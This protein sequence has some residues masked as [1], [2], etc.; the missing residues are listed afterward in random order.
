[1]HQSNSSV[2]L[3]DNNSIAGTW[4]NYTPVS[5]EGSCLRHGDLIHFA[6]VGFRFETDPPQERKNHFT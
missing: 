5:I 3:L 4:V 6:R 2:L 1:M